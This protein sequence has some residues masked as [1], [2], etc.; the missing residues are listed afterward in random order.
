MN[1]NEIKFFSKNELL[2]YDASA[3][4]FLY[5]LKSMFVKI[6]RN[7]WG[8]YFDKNAR[9]VWTVSAVSDAI[10]PADNVRN[11]LERE[12]IR[13]ILSEIV[14]DRPI[15]SACEIGCGYGRLIMLLKEYA[16]RVV[17]FERESHLVDV[18]KVLLPNIE[19]YQCDSLDEINQVEPGPFDFAMTWTVLQHLTDDNCRA[20]ISSI[21]HLVPR[22]YILIAEKTEEVAVTRNNAEG[23]QF[24]SN[25]RSVKI[26][27]EWM[28]P[29]IL[30]K[31]INSIVENTYHNKVPGTCMLFKNQ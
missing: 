11:Y 24:I 5:L 10:G 15:L 26:Y 9:M 19:F 7:L 31:T 3:L 22:G 25:A 2:L 20:V 1:Q 28:K 21:K 29:Y 12:T 4:P 30:I 18:A 16:D 6:R 14:K 17:G 8:R 13:S 27:E 23:H